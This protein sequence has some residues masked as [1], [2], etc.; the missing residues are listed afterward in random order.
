[1]A[2][3]R[4][5]HTRVECIAIKHFSDVTK[6]RDLKGCAVI[7]EKA[8]SNSQ[9]AVVLDGAVVGHLGDVVGPQVASAID[10]GQTFTATIK[11]S[12]H[13]YENYTNSSSPAFSFAFSEGRVST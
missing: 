9:V 13:P 1:M 11:E 3:R 12:F 7:L 8:A 5:F 2:R 4:V 10:S 6:V